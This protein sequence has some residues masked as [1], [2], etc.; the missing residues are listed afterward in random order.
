[1]IIVKISDIDLNKLNFKNY[2]SV[3]EKMARA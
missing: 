1:M 2:C 3:K